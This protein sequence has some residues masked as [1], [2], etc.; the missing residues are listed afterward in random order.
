MV[1]PNTPHL[2][3]DQIDRDWYGFGHRYTMATPNTVSSDA[4]LLAMLS[5]IGRI[6]DVMPTVKSSPRRKRR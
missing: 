6:A 4:S 3:Q 2:Q 5:S 1:R